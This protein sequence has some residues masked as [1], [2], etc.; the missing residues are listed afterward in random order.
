MAQELSAIEIINKYDYLKQAFRY[1]VAHNKSNGAPYH[2]LNHL[3]TVTKSTYEALKY[4][5]LLRKKEAKSTLIAAI[6]HDGNHS[7][8]AQTDAENIVDAKV[9][10]RK[11]YDSLPGANK[12]EL[13]FIFSLLDAT[14][15]PYVIEPSNLTIYQKILRDADLT[16]LF[17]YNWIHQSVYGLSKE[18]N[19]EFSKFVKIQRAFMSSVEFNTNWGKMMKK[20]HW[21]RVNKELKALESCMNC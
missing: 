5:G 17:Q 6:L 10:L 3:F 14:Q 13:K 16:Q 9:F 19:I 11:F 2:N 12:S 4:E 15:Y 7:M 21:A 20:I 8:G 18:L 1:I